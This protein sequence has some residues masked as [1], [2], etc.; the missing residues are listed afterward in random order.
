MRRVEAWLDQGLGS[1]VLKH[2][3]ASAVLTGTMHRFDGRRY[4]LAAYVVM[5]NHVHALVRPLAGD[6]DPLERILQTWKRFSARHVNE[7]LG[8]GGSLWQEE[9]FDRIVRD[10]E[11]LYRCIQYIATNAVRA[12]LSPSASPRWIRPEWAALGWRFADP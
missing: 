11:H 3:H 7:R 9:T 4:E 12:G 2:P 8:Q 6:A 5:P 1:C 10:E